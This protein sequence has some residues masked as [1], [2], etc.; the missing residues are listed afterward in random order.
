MCHLHR[1][2]RLHILTNWTKASVGAAIRR[3]TA[4]RGHTGLSPEHRWL[5]GRSDWT[6]RRGGSDDAVNK[7]Q[8]EETLPQEPSLLLHQTL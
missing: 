7:R 8:L 1:E 4:A 2:K 3:Q 6:R 5:L